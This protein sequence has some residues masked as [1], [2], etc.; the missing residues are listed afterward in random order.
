[1]M[2]IA[3]ASADIAFI[4]FPVLCFFKHII[5]KLWQHRDHV[6]LSYMAK[7]LASTRSLMYTVASSQ[8]T[9][10]ERG[11]QLRSQTDYGLTAL[12]DAQLLEAAGHLRDFPPAAPTGKVRPV[13]KKFLH[14]AEDGPL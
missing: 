4:L 3:I 14:P 10:S 6:L 2:T 1:M 5:P 11:R 9:V 12:P 7:H 13:G 8:K